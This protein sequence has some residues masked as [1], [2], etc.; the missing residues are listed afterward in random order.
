MNI[1]QL[2]NY[3]LVKRKYYN[4]IAFDK[5]V[6]FAQNRK[7][8]LITSHIILFLQP[9]KSIHQI[10]FSATENLQNFSRWQ[11]LVKNQNIFITPLPPN[12]T[13]LSPYVV[14]S[15]PTPT[16][17]LSTPSSTTLPPSIV[18]YG[19]AQSKK[20]PLLLSCRLCPYP[21][22]MDSSSLWKNDFMT[23]GECLTTNK[24]KKK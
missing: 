7:L 1:Q 9:S 2:K 4:P 14:S 12:T 22:V 5:I 17:T 20:R 11:W 6:K 23:E 21:L 15:S 18:T 19:S 24:V 10:F 3:F 13:T 16:I 8:N